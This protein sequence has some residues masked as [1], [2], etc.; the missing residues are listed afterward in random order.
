MSKIEIRKLLIQLLK[1]SFVRINVDNNLMNQ[2]DSIGIVSLI[3]L[4]EEKFSIEIFPPEM[5]DRN[6]S[7]LETVTDWIY[8]KLEKNADRKS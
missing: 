8:L 4:L 6:F 2:I 1:N 5:N 3:V 7:S